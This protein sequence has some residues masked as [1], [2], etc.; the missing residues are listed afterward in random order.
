[1]LLRDQRAIFNHVGLGY[2]PLHKQ[3][4]VENLFIKF[5]PEK[6]KSIACYY[7]GKIGHKSYMCN[8]K[9][10]TN[11]VR[12]ETRVKNS[13]PSATKKVTQVLVPRG[14]NAR[15][16]VVSKKSQISKLTQ[17]SYICKCIMQSRILEDG[18]ET[19]AAQDI[20]VGIRVNSSPSSLKKMVELLHLETMAKVKT[21]ALVKF[22]LTLLPLLTMFFM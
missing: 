17:L 22:K 12:V 15:Y 3:R 10:K 20:C 19:K 11:Q 13:V 4:T 8:N 6:Q 14:T 1:M 18:I 21:L 16:I 5:I 7:Y 9:P 2:K